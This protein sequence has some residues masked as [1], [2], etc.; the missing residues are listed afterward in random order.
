MP[1]KRTPAGGDSVFR[2]IDVVGDAWSWLV[3]REAIFH[4]VRRFNDFRV[5]LGIARETLRTR[6]ERL[7]AGALLERRPGPEGAAFSE[8][9]LT[10]RGRDFFACLATAMRW[11]DRWR[12]DDRIK[13]PKARHVGCG[14]P[15]EA[16]LRCSECGKELEARAVDF[17]LAPGARAELRRS[18]EHGQRHRGP[19]LHLL[20][21]RRAC[22]IARTLQVIGD[23]WSGLV[24]RESFLGTRRF[25]DF[26]ERLGIASN[27]LSERLARLVEVRILAKRPYHDRPRRHEYR[28]TKKGFDLY[29]VPL[30]MLTWGDRWLSAGR[31]RLLLSHRSC[32]KRFTAMLTCGRCG[33]MVERDDIAPSVAGR[34]RRR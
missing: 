11:G 28:L 13:L 32:G 29:P 8:Y 23:R 33:N 1:P 12:V 9:V 3:L 17:T 7:T 24:I 18:N 14:R 20:E 10:E 15:F 34:S 31:S 27:V 30:A 4:G 21:R 2:T 22:S 25:D 16:I 6:L 5:R 26:Q 19:G